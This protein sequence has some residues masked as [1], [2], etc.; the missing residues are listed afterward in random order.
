MPAPVQ[1]NGAPHIGVPPGPQQ[2]PAESERRYTMKAARSRKP[3]GRSQCRAGRRRL[4]TLRLVREGAF[5]APEGYPAPGAPIRSSED[6]YTRMA[7][8]ANRELAE[9]FWVLALDSQS[10]VIGD[11]PYV[12][13]RGI[14]NSS[15]VHAREVFGAAIQA[16]AA[17]VILVHNHPSGDPTPS[18]ED[19]AITRQ[20][21]EAGRLLDIPVYDHVIIG[22]GRYTSLAEAGLL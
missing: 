15:L 19:R 12:I 3:A 11:A 18:A 21:V 17:G 16:R 13:T 22:R 2:E 1:V 10:Q 9:S 5:R 7:P 14:L 8:Y 4:S 6:V 20:L